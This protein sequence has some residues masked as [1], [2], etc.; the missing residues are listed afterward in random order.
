MGRFPFSGYQSVGFIWDIYTALQHTTI[1]LQYLSVLVQNQ[2]GACA[3]GRP[4]MPVDSIREAVLTV[5]PNRQYRGIFS[6]TTPATTIPEWIP[7]EGEGCHDN[8]YLHHSR[9][10]DLRDLRPNPGTK[11]EALTAFV[12]A[13]NIL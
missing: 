3:V 6:P 8:L 10:Q 9:T 5:S 1:K 12:M 11:R 7:G 4:T 13:V 2:R